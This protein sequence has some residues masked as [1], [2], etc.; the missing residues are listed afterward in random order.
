MIIINN[1]LFMIIID[2]YKCSTVVAQMVYCSGLSNFKGGNGSMVRLESKIKNNF[3]FY[4][5]Y[6]YI[7][8]LINIIYIYLFFIFYYY[9]YYY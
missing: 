2:N 3:F 7:F 6:I 4:K 5:Y 1:Y 8:F 9:Y